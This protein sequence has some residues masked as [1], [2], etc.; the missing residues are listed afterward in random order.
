[1]CIRW[2]L[3][4]SALLFSCAGSQ[5]A[6]APIPHDDVDGST[7]PPLTPDPVGDASPGNDPAARACVHLQ[8]LGC[9]EAKGHLVKCAETIRANS[10][11]GS[12]IHPECIIGAHSPEE[13]RTCNVRCRQ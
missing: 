4:V 5:P 10:N 11:P 3:T 9:P 6:P 7:G 12:G 2:M 1:M 13:V 8:E